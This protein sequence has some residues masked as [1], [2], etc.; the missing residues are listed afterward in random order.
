MS[1]HHFFGTTAFGWRTGTDLQQ[2]KINMKRDIPGREKTGQPY[3]IFDV[4]LPE[5][6]EYDIENYSPQVQGAK[7]IEKGTF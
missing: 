3:A 6:A 5:S 1:T 7:L 4:P 2:L